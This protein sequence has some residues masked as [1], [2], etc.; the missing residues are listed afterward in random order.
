MTL[1]CTPL[2]LRGAGTI[3]AF[4]FEAE[5]AYQFGEADID[6]PLFNDLNVDFEEWGLN[7][8]LGYTFD[9]TWQPRVYA[10]FAYLGG[11][12]YDAAPCGNS[13]KPTPTPRPSTASSPTGNTVNSW[14]TPT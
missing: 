13:G 6:G 12:D 9:M 8:E 2:G 5:A 1:T 14:P 3:G 11:G 7:L 10:G 4:D